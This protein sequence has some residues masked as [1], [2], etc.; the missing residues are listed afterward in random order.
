MVGEISKT[1][2]S[3]YAKLKEFNIGEIVV[4]IRIPGMP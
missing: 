1:F 4:G 2:I 3:T